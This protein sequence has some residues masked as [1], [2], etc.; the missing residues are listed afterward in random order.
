MAN[1]SSSRKDPLPVFCF[2]VTFNE[3]KTDAF[4]KSVGGLGYERLSRRD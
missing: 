2:K 3:L 4:F 1:P